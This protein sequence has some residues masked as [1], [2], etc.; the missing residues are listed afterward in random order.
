MHVGLLSPAWPSSAYP[1]GIVTYVHCLREELLRQG[2]RV[3]VLTVS[4][5]QNHRDDSV[6]EIRR[7]WRDRASASLRRWLFLRAP[8]V[9]DYGPTIA[10]AVRRLHAEDPLDVLEMEESFGFPLRVAAAVRVPVVVRLHGPAFLTMVELMR[11]ARRIQVTV[12]RDRPTVWP[13]K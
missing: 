5:D 6:R 3:S 9:F 11:S 8:G 7:D 12:H 4:L 13:R 10:R 2:H 1:N